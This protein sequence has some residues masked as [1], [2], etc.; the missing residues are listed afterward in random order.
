MNHVCW[1]LSSIVMQLGDFQVAVNESKIF[2]NG[3]IFEEQI[4][5][6]IHRRSA[7]RTIC[8]SSESSEIR[9]DRAQ[10]HTCQELRDDCGCEM[11]IEAA[12]KRFSH[13][14]ELEYTL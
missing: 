14:Q 10:L 1:W 4:P 8:T 6:V 7:T 3:R 13:Q 5:T 2:G 12:V 9:G 11:I